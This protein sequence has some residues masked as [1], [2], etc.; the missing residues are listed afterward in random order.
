MRALCS[1]VHNDP[2]HLARRTTKHKFARTRHTIH[3]IREV[4]IFVL[5]EP[6]RS[7]CGSNPGRGLN[8]SLAALRNRNASACQ[9]FCYVLLVVRYTD[10]TYV[11][12]S[13]PDCL[14]LL[15]HTWCASGPV[16]TTKKP[17]RDIDA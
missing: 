7:T 17:R 14:I 13:G 5:L 4:V 16:R 11:K 8:T 2:P 15:G 3:E 12:L 10:M 1:R 9:R 6:I